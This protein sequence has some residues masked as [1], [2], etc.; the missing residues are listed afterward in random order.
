MIL[1]LLLISDMALRKFNK[2]L[3]IIVPAEIRPGFY[4]KTRTRRTG[5][6]T[7]RLLLC[8]IYKWAGRE[9]LTAVP[10]P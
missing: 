4:S 3:V 10:V 1:L 7:G 9:L 2:I 6:E 5:T 8:N